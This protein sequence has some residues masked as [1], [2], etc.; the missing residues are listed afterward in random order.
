RLV[1]CNSNFQELHDLPDESI[2]TG[3]SYEAVVAAG[4]KPVVRT[5]G[6]HDGAPTHGAR[7]FEAQLDDGRWLHIS[8]RRT[9]DGG[10][11]SVGTDITTIKRHEEKLIDSER[12]L[13]ATV[14]DLRA[15]Q[16]ALESQA[17]QLT[18]LAEKYAEEKTRAEDANQAKSKF[19][20]N[21]SHEL[22]T[23]LNA[24]IGFSEIMGS[25]MFGP[26]GADRYTEYCRDIHSSGQYLLDVIN[27]VLDMSKIEAG[28]MRLDRERI[29]LD[30]MLTDSMRVVANRAAEKKL[31]LTLEVEPEV[32][33]DADRRAC[34]QIVLNLLSNAVKFTPDGGRVDVHGRAR[35]ESVVIAIDDTGI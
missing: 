28:R 4:R 17:Q 8:E 24:I 12:R 31:E 2:R 16:Q 27:D 13:M 33:F 30:Q 11:V 10:Y 21:M 23:P 25:G 9:K 19:L 35:G 5:T 32:G 29:T 18:D 20:A 26:L 3:I 34:K 22:R 14:A 7:T 15:S 1:L 6:T